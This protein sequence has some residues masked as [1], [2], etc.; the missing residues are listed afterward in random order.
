MS[1]EELSET[2]LDHVAGGTSIDG[3]TKTKSIDGSSTSKTGIEVGIEGLG[4]KHDG[5][6]YVKGVTH[7][8][9]EDGRDTSFDTKR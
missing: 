5:T 8:I 9:D 1:K 3:V 2:E 6:Y 7:E 4:D